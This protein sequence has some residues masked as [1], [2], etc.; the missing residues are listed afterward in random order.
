[1]DFTEQQ[2]LI[3]LRNVNKRAQLPLTSLPS[4]VCVCTI[5]N[6][7]SLHEKFSLTSLPS[8]VYGQQQ[9]FLGTLHEKFSLTS[10]PS[11]V[12]DQQAFLA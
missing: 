5:N 2:I 4:C 6:K 11:C 12:Y 8:C 9:A 3:N 10:L 7:L 1:M